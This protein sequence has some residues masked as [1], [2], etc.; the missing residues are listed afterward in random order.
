MTTVLRSSC[1]HDRWH[2]VPDNLASTSDPV[3]YPLGLNT[4]KKIVRPVSS[5]LFTP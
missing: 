5:F 4:R 1:A 2:K 3:L